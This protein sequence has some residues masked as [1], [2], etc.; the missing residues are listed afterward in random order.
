MAKTP[1]TFRKVVEEKNKETKKVSAQEKTTSGIAELN[2]SIMDQ[3]A[4]VELVAETVESVGNR[5]LDKLDDIQS[6]V[7]L[8]IDSLQPLGNIK[9]SLANQAELTEKLNSNI[10]QLSGVLKDKFSSDTKKVVDTP[11]TDEEI[12]KNLPLKVEDDD[13][14]D[15]IGKLIVT[16]SPPAEDDND[17]RVIKEH[18]KDDED[19]KNKGKELSLLEMLNKNV[20]SGFKASY[21][22]TDRIA[23]M[24]FKFTVSAAINAVKWAGI[25]LGIVLTLDLIIIHFKHWGKMFKENFS[26]FEEMLG[27]VAPILGDLFS[28]LSEVKKYF[29]AG[30]WGNLTL[31]ILKGVVSLAEK[32]IMGLEYA[33][34]KLGASIL[35]ALGKDDWADRLEATVIERYALN[36][37]YQPTKEEIELVGRVRGDQMYDKYTTDS[38]MSAIGGNNAKYTDSYNVPMEEV[39][40]RAKEYQTT[41]KGIKSGEVTKETLREEKTREFE[42]ETRINNLKRQA[43]NNKNNP[44]ELDRISGEL[45]DIAGQLM[46]DESIQDDSNLDKLSSKASD[47]AQEIYSSIPE[48]S[49]EEP[50]E[51]Q[52]AK[53]AET[54][55]NYEN[56]SSETVNNQ[57]IQATNNNISNHK[58]VVNTDTSTNYDAPGMYKSQEVN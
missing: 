32:L 12:I 6:G 3:S 41:T 34:G 16:P 40:R 55:Q 47:L 2:D 26:K 13:L 39:E 9:D 25:L 42:I 29:L 18:G 30:D 8:V 53:T 20:G 51:T 19:K 43:E 31:A 24:L 1:S 38:E 54:I 56:T 11:S 33:L 4:A 7:E 5:T 37:G 35:R 45:D 36:A 17:T 21:K 49:A 15:K 50:K 52:E 27:P 10:A 58:T 14:S 48:V 46:A 23:G 44:V 22:M 28:T 57:N